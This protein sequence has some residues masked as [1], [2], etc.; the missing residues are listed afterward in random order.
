MYSDMDSSCLTGGY[1]VF[2][3]Q[4]LRQSWSELTLTALL[5]LSAGAF[6]D[7]PYRTG[8]ALDSFGSQEPHASSF[9]QA[10]FYARYARTHGTAACGACM[11]ILRRP[12]GCGGY[13]STPG[14][15]TKMLFSCIDV[16]LLRGLARLRGCI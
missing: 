4:K 8:S 13:P 9:L 5:L 12:R 2:G 16:L 15:G 1:L 7:A 10:P 11:L 3:A 14:R 6:I